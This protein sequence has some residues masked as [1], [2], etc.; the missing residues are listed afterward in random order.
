MER[1][2]K[3]LMARVYNATSKN[4]IVEFVRMQIDYLED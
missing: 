4:P 2:D 1:A 3:Y